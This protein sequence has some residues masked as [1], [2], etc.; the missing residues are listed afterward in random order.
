MRS[1]ARR[2]MEKRQLTSPARSLS[3]WQKSER[4]RQI[5]SSAMKAFHA[6][7]HTLP[8]CTAISKSTGDQCGNLAMANGKCWCHG[9]RT[10]AGDGWHRP[11]WPNDGPAGERKLNRKLATFQRAAEQRERKLA[12]ATEDERHNYEAWKKTHEPGKQANRAM[13]RKQRQDAASFR[14]VVEAPPADRPC[15]PELNALEIQIAVA[16]RRAAALA[17]KL[18]DNEGIFG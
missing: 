12:G 15:D 11:V 18:A 14:S 4:F 16:R 5:G 17:S 6:I 8:K 13:K 10:P 3:A 2:V 7:R 1:E 9:G